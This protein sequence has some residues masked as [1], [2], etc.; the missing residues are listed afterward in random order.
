MKSMSFV[1]ASSHRVRGGAGHRRRLRSGATHQ[2]QTRARASERKS[3]ELCELRRSEPRP[4]GRSSRKCARGAPSLSA[5]SR[6]TFE[7]ELEPHDMRAANYRA[8]AVGEGGAVRELERTPTRTYKGTVR[9]RD[10]ARARFTIDEGRI[11]G[12]IITNG[13]LLFVEPARNFSASAAP[14]D[15]VF[16]AGSS[17]R[18]ESFGECGVTAGRQGGGGSR[19]H[20]NQ[21][22]A[23]FGRRRR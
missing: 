7:L 12:L 10:G 20:R 13:E 22:L 1:C 19:A 11:E 2:P 16:Y 6:G 17:V 14:E 9:G 5:K 21:E 3:V 15:Y 4:F 18:A 23:G 8:V